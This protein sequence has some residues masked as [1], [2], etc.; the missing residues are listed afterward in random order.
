[1]L[2]EQAKMAVAVNRTR[3][4]PSPGFELGV[5]IEFVGIVKAHFMVTGVY[6]YGTA[7]HYVYW[8]SQFPSKKTGL[9]SPSIGTRMG[10]VCRPCTDLTS[11]S[12]RANCPIDDRLP[13]ITLFTGICFI[14]RFAVIYSSKKDA[15]NLAVVIY[16]HK[17]LTLSSAYK[18]SII[19]SV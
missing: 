18:T 16:R 19:F 10:R 6:R 4:P 17:S 5:N 2:C 3:Y 9:S 14:I 1:V 13:Y 12:G 15:A 11:Y 8:V 7:D